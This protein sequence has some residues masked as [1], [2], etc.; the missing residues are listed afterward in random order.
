MLAK[1][2]ITEMNLTIPVLLDSMNGAAEKA[3]RGRPDRL[4]VVDIDGNVA[5]YGDRGPRGFKPADAE[6]AL[7]ELLANEGRMKKTPGK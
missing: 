4:C 3:Y 1:K 6:K 2:C 7:K 5:Y